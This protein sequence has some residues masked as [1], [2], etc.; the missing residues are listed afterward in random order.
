[1][2]WWELSL[3][4]LNKQ[5]YHRWNKVQALLGPQN[6]KL[7]SSSKLSTKEVKLDLS[8]LRLVLHGLELWSKSKARYSFGTKLDLEPI[9]KTQSSTFRGSTEL[10]NVNKVPGSD[11]V[12]M[13]KFLSAI[14]LHDPHPRVVLVLDHL[15]AVGSSKSRKE[16]RT[17]N[18]RESDSGWN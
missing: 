5:F 14:A 6:Q 10:L 15:D 16:N 8:K 4:G 17:G 1:M 18:L 2:A 7:G 11:L 12:K 9:I 3:S 13:D